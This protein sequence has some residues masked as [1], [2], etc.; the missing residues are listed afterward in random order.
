M[1]NF[2]SQ[3]VEAG[4]VDVDDLRRLDLEVE[5]ELAAAIEAAEAAPFPELSELAA[6]V[7]AEDAR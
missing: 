7:Y 4:L 5:E 3:A 2:E 6:D 1:Q